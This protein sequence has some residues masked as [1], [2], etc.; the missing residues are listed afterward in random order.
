MILKW[1]YK[2][3]TPIRMLQDSPQR[4]DSVDCTQK[5]M[6]PGRSVPVPN[7]YPNRGFL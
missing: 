4:F 1:E 2:I 6:S 3:F 7:G 5:V